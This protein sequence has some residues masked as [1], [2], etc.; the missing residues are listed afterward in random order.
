MQL[1]ENHLRGDRRECLVLEQVN[2]SRLIRPG[3]AQVAVDALRQVL[4]KEPQ[5]HKGTRRIGMRI[6][7]GKAP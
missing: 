2:E 5:L 4:S 1:V 3:Q 6:C 7:L